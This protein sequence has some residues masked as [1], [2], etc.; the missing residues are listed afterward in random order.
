[1]SQG[2]PGSLRISV[3]KTEPSGGDEP[4]FYVAVECASTHEDQHFT[5]KGAIELVFP[6]DEL[7]WVSHSDAL[8]AE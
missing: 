6:I 5:P 2:L 4:R 1:M 7:R 8:Q 3:L